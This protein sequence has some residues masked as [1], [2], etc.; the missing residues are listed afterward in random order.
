VQR[1]AGEE[2]EQFRLH[3]DAEFWSSIPPI[4]GAVAACQRLHDGGHELV[5]VTAL[6]EK[7]AQ[8][9]LANLRTCG[10][11]IDKVYAT[12][13]QSGAV[14]PKAEIIHQLKPGAFV[15]DYLPYMD[16]ISADIHTALIMRS[17]N[18]SPNVGPGL[19]AVSSMHVDL[20]EFSQW[21]L[22]NG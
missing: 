21:W 10:F 8:A 16:G 13:H 19:S 20:V 9:R 11:P 2:L 4:A 18:G 3:F 17:P 14:S 5:C 7:F 15:D 6:E 22:A 1:L 12:G